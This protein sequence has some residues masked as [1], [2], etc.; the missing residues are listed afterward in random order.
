MLV[1]KLGGRNQVL[2]NLAYHGPAPSGPRR[3]HYTALSPCPASAAAG[4]RGKH[5]PRGLTDVQAR[6]L[7]RLVQLLLLVGRDGA[8]GGGVGDAGQHVALAHLQQTP[9]NVQF[10]SLAMHFSPTQVNML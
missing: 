10:G 5:P 1:P 8:V 3:L 9:Q 6:T 4:Q 2:V 7:M